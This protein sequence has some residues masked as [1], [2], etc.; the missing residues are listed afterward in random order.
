MDP[1]EP[2]SRMQAAR[3]SQQKV[4]SSNGHLTLRCHSEEMPGFMGSPAGQRVSLDVCQICPHWKPR[5]GG[6]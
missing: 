1:A 5:E 3:C 6:A 4:V 2:R